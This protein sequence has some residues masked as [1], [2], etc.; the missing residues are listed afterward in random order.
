MSGPDPCAGCAGARTGRAETVEELT[1]RGFLTQSMLAAAAAV[2][3]AACG[4]GQIGT[5]LPTNVT[6]ACEIEEDDDDGGG[7]GSQTSGCGASTGPTGKLVVTLASFPALANV[8]GA[9]RVDGNSRTP[10][11]LVRTAAAAFVALSMT[12]PHQGTR[13]SIVNGGFFCP[14]HGARFTL[15]GQWSGGQ[16]TSSLHSYP[17]VYDAA[18]GT[19]TIG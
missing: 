9:A 2:L 13:V 5:G 4:D 10:I 3:V 18:A 14:N 19:V 11:A 6:G 8:G 7:G 16:P 15:T 1:R 17:A 12:C